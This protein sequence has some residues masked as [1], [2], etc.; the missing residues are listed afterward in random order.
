MVYALVFGGSILITG[1]AFAIAVTISQFMALRTPSQAAT[2]WDAPLVMAEDEWDPD[3][4]YRREQ[5]AKRE[6]EATRRRPCR[7]TPRI[8]IFAISQDGWKREVPN[9]GTIV[10]G[11]R[12]ELHAL[13]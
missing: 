1:I 13:T 5:R 9:G 3:E 6:R 8:K 4:K 10:L 11:E 12:V 2:N 7:L